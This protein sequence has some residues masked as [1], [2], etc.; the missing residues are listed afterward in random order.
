MDWPG[1]PSLGPWLWS[2]GPWSATAL[3]EG[4][5][6]VARRLRVAPDKPLKGRCRASS[7]QR[8]ARA[9]E[10]GRLDSSR[11]VAGGLL[12]EFQP[13]KFIA[14]VAQEFLEAF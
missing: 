13:R 5:G 14:A 12:L 11:L 7:R 8:Q 3:L 4:Q 1:P 6:K 10:G 9:A 2:A